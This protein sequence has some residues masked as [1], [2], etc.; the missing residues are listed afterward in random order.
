MSWL[1]TAI[2]IALG[3]ALW[4]FGGRMSRQAVMVLGF[5]AGVPAGAAV[6]EWMQGRRC[7]PCSP[8]CS[9]RSSA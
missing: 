7:R 3:A 6:A 5:A 4:A 1:A 8:R 2:A 9:A